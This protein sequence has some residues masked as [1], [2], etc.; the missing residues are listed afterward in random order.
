M[1]CLVAIALVL[2]F[3]HTQSQKHDRNWVFGEGGG[4]DFSNT[5]NIKTYWTRTFN[6]EVAASISDS[7]GQLLFY[8]GRNNDF[9]GGLNVYDKNHNIILNL[10]VYRTQIQ[11]KN[12]YRLALLEY[13]S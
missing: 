5:S 12:F 6:K 9:F 13:L 7:N 11:N 8:L 3:H 2:C 4:I 10:V 1:R